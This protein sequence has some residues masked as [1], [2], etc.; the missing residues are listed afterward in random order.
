MPDLRGQLSATW[1]GSALAVRLR[2]LINRP[3][4][5]KP[6]DVEI[7][8]RDFIRTLRLRPRGRNSVLIRLTIPLAQTPLGRIVTRVDAG[9]VVLETRERNNMLSVA[10]GQPERRRKTFKP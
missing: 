6:F 4:L 3:K 2:V 7:R 1:D 8:G 5:V 9:D 10:I